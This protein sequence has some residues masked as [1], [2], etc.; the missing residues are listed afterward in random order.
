[1]HRNLF[2]A[3]IVLPSIAIL[4]SPIVFLIAFFYPVFRYALLSALI[5]YLLIC[6]SSAVQQT[7]NIKSIAMMVNM[8]IGHH[9]SYGV[10]F[11]SGLLS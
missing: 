10:G 4:I 5:I 11:L 3:F 8:Y 7:R 9:L 2:N 6:I 1:M